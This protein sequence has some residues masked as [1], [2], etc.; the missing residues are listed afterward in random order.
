MYRLDIVYLLSVPLTMAGSVS[1][2]RHGGACRHAATK[3]CTEPYPLTHDNHSRMKG[4]T[5]LFQDLSCA[6]TP[7]LAQL[8]ERGIIVPAA[9]PALISLPRYCKSNFRRGFINSI[10]QTPS[11]LSVEWLLLHRISAYES[12]SLLTPPV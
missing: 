1:K 3:S 2:C 4:S 10:S 8:A 11:A 5:L 6:G 7:T 12:S 9:A